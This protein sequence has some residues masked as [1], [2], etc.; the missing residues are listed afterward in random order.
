MLMKKEEQEKISY[1]SRDI[2]NVS[3]NSLSINLR[4]MNAAISRLKL[5]EQW[6][7]KSISVNGEKI[8]YNPIFILKL[9]KKEKELPT[10]VFL[11]MLLHCLFRHNYITTLLNEK[12]WN[13]ACDIAVENMVNELGI[14]AT[15]ITLEDQQAKEISN[16]NY[17]V[18]YISAVNL[19]YYFIETNLTEK[20]YNELSQIF[21]FDNHESW[22]KREKKPNTSEETNGEE[23]NGE[24]ENGEE[25]NG[26]EEQNFA[27]EDSFVEWSKERLEDW[28]QLAEQIQMDL[29]TFNK[30][31]GNT[32]GG[33]VQ[34]LREINREK[35]DYSEFLRKFAVLGETMRINDDEFDYIFYTYGMNLY[36]KMPLI[37]P[38]E[39]KDVKQIREFVIAIDTSGSTSGNLVQRFLNKTY[40]ILCQQ[41]NFFSKINLHIVQCDTEIQ[42]HVKITSKKE[43]DLYLKGMKIYGLGGTDFRPVFRLV[44][45]LIEKKEFVNLKG[46]IYFTDGYGCFPQQQTQYKTAFV[47]IDDELNNYDVPSWAIKLILKNEDI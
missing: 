37:E 12:Y 25:E 17:K 2:L 33:L 22:F 15:K 44:N 34:N 7:T 30:Q 4:F 29:E 35:Y 14:Q 24:E 10:R 23:T 19:Y 41:E 21:S 1:V 42:E 40:N 8:E 36:G 26:E 28:K 5:V 6:E 20:K 39:Y 13:L 16:L 47:F 11:H 32:A 43:F 38:L 27:H 18:K 46:M 9:Y 31:R 45:S 3:R